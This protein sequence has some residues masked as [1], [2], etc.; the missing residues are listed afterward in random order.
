MKD[1]RHIFHCHQWQICFSV[2]FV[3]LSLS[4][5]VVWGSIKS[6]TPSTS[7]YLQNT[8]YTG[9]NDKSGSELFSAV[10]TIAAGVHYT[11]N[12][13]TYDELW[14]AYES[15]DVYPTGHA[16]AGT[17]WDMYANCYYSTSD[18]VSQ[19]KAECNGGYNREHSMPKSW[20]GG[21]NNY[22]STN[23]GCD[24]VHLVPT[25]AYVNSDRSNYAFGEVGTVA[26]QFEISKRGTSKSSLS[27]TES[28]VAGTSVSGLS[29]TVF[30]P[31][32]EYK[33][34]FA[35]I[36][37]YMRARYPSLNLA[38]A[39]GGQVHFST[40]T[41]AASD[42]YYGLKNYSVILLMK[43]HRQ[44]PVSQKEIDRNNQIEKMQGNRNPFVDYPILA[45]YLWG[46]YAGNTFNQSNAVGSF[47]SAFEVG[48]SD[49]D[50]ATGPRITLSTS[51]L[52]MDATAPNS[53]STKTFTVTGAD[54]TSK[55]SITNTSGD[56]CF[57]MSPN[58]ITSGYNGTTTITVT[59]APTAEGNHSATFTVAST[60][61]TSKTITVSGTCAATRT[62]T[63]KVNNAVY[64]TGSPTTQVASGSK[65]STLPSNPAVPSGCS[66]KTFVGWTATAINSETNTVPTD[67]FTTAEGSPTITANTIF[68]AVFASGSA[69]T[70]AKA[71]SI[72]TGDK[73]VFACEE[74]TME[75]TSFSTTSTIYGIG[76]SY[77]GT[78]AGTMVFDVVA[79]S[80]NSTYAF[81]NG[82]NYINW[83]SGNSLSTSTTLSANTSWSVSITSGNATIN[84]ASDDTR[85]ILWN[86][87]SPRFAAYGS[88]YSNYKSIQ[89]YK[90]SGGASGYITTC[91][92]ASVT[93]S[94]V[95]FHKNDGTSTTSTQ[96]EEQGTTTN[97]TSNSWSREHYTFLGWSTNSSAT[98]ATY[99]DGASYTFSADA[100]LYA[101]WKEDDKYTVT[102]HV[103]GST[104]AVQY[105]SGDAL[106]LPSTP[107]ACDNGRVFKGWTTNSS[108]SG[109][110]TGLIT[111]ASG[112]VTA[113]ADYY[114]VYATAS[115]GS[116]SGTVDTDDF[117]LYS[118]TIT[119]GDYLI[120]YDNGAMNTTVTSNRL[121]YTSVTPSN[122]V[123][124]TTDATIIWH[125]AASGNYWTIYNA[126]ES[127]YAAANGTKN[128][129]TTNTDG[130]DG[131]SLWTVSGSSTYE[132]VNKNNS[133]NSVNANLR[134]NGTYGF[135]CYATGTGGALSLYKRVTTSGSG[136]TTYTDYGTSCSTTTYTITWNANGGTC[137][138]TSSSV[139]AG[140]A[141]GTLPQA[142]KDGYT[143]NGWYTAS[144]GGTK[145]I[146][147]TVPTGDAEY[148]AQYTANTYTITYDKGANG[149]GTVASTTQTHGEVATLSS[150]TFSREGYT[151]DGW[152]TTDGGNKAYDLGGSY[153]AN[154]AITLYP[155]WSALPTYTVTFKVGTENHATFEGWAGKS[156][157]GIS[158]PSAC[159]GY[160]FVGWSTQQYGTTNTSAPA[161]DYT[162][163]VPAAN[164]TYYAVF[165]T[166]GVAV[167]TMLWAE[168]FAHFETNTPSDAGIGSGTTIYGDATIAYAQSSTNTKGYAENLAGG[169]SPE[170]LIY[171]ST[172]TWTI[173]GIKMANATAMSLSFLANKTTFSVA[174]NE[175]TK[176]SVSGSGKSW[177][178]SVADGQ[179]AP[180]TFNIIITN[181]GSQNARVDNVVLSVTAID[182][183]GAVFTTAKEFTLTVQSPDNAKGTVGIE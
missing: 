82:S 116:G 36:Y 52:T 143:F 58:N 99:S 164:T 43:W 77:S 21:S 155:H 15:S 146:A 149:T 148:F 172:T 40:T 90:V 72:A 153:S 3:I 136:T 129:A 96:Q 131:K 125:I 94:T 84:N 113:N 92:G 108:Y 117:E 115:G 101:V 86:S 34:D 74:A 80:S 78:P 102:W 161:I 128:Q 14:T 183:N 105:Y 38:Q 81:K 112:T 75:L 55:I 42:T 138:T 126:G 130:T 123:I 76:T 83:S 87:G 118:G 53:S 133:A 145:I 95:T 181:T 27:V 67:L 16:H 106:A 46:K 10:S 170:L 29:A 24:L 119:E 127:K 157:S 178:I 141:V 120:V 79:G 70:I 63:W 39:D 142:T 135:A 173:S 110:G 30:E 12:K 65:V 122:D 171:K 18:H 174:T 57:S 134:K 93:Y 98:S 182:S 31:A 66:G 154:A 91:S 176:L 17:I 111:S 48:V 73:V 165:S 47:E 45:E 97:L 179:T 162:G 59:Y 25:D 8:Y 61:A 104:N 32:D 151:Q 50:K 147:S 37:M 140:S 177:T 35:R 85:R 156:I 150:N 11:Y 20:F 41:S 6:N 139:T 100:D 28:T 9:A 103:N 4:A 7:T 69:Q 124:T 121:Q 49:G 44:D 180:E 1:V 167:G 109:D 2:V 51:S 68:Y 158:I 114:A 23:Q 169:S 13:L 33:G 71:S 159:D 144:T 54:L 88:N 160:T 152:S 132:F 19:M 5:Q 89:L 26:K 137:A 56:G 62:V 166:N 107:S 175:T 60:G 64:T 163:L 22:S 168:N